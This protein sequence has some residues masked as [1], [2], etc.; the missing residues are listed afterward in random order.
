MKP[1]WNRGKD[2]NVV[3]VMVDGSEEKGG[4]WSDDGP[5]TQ[6]CVYVQDRDSQ[7]WS[8]RALAETVEVEAIASGE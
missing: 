5:M 1:A 4:E 2:S 8:A 7:R 3:L 6:R